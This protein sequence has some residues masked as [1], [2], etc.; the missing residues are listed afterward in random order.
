MYGTANGFVEFFMSL[1]K[2]TDFLWAKYD[3]TDLDRKNLNMGSLFHSSIL[4]I[5]SA[6]FKFSEVTL[7]GELYCLYDDRPV[8]KKKQ[9]Q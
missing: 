5:F 2:Q 3:W 1:L 8:K 7:S 9:K 4:V 6:L